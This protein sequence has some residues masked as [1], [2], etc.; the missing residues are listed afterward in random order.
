M[1]GVVA[2]LYLWQLAAW[3][4]FNIKGM[5]NGPEQIDAFRKE[6][7]EILE[8]LNKPLVVIIDNLDRCLPTNAIHTLEAIRLFLFLT[9]TAFIDRVSQQTILSEATL[10]SWK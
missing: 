9:N 7:G 2:A 10:L 4:Q 3:L 8:E 1:A 6:Y 5:G